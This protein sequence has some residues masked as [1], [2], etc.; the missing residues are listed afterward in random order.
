MVEILSLFASM[1]R[2]VMM[3]PR[4]FPWGTLK[5]HFIWVQLN[6]ELPKVFE[7]FFQIRDEACQGNIPWVPRAAGYDPKF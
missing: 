4:S 6:V 2:S 7:G 1:Q 5:V 3:F